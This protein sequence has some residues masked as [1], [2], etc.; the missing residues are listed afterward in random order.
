VVAVLGCAVAPF[1][2]GVFTIAERVVAPARVATAMTVLASAT[3]LG[4]A[5]GSS[6]AG[7]LADDHGYTAAFAVTVS[8]MTLALA[9][10]ASSQRRLRS[11]LTGSTSDEPGVGSVEPAREAGR[12]S[13]AV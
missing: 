11:A 1:M 9:L 12:D 6:V 10:V 3:G 2:I 8:A 7:R 4:Y 5:V 13:V